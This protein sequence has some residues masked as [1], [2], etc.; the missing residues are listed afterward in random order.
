MKQDG[1][2]IRTINDLIWLIRQAYANVPS[3]R[4]QCKICGGIAKG[5]YMCLK[6]LKSEFIGRV[7]A[8]IG[9]E[10]LGAVQTTAV[11]EERM[12]GM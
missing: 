7:G 10:Y 2:S 3:T 12:K 1:A 8:S 6:C 11:L 9:N 5:D 4:G